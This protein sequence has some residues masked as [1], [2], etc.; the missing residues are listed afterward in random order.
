MLISDT[1]TADRYYQ[2]L[3]A[4]DADFLGTFYVGVRTT[5]IFCIAT[6]RARK[7]KR[8]NVTFYT[9]LKELLDHG[10]RPCKIC[11][12]T[13]HAHRAPAPVSRALALM[14]EKPKEK[15][16][17]RDLREAGVSPDALRRWFNEHYGMTFQAYQRMYRINQAYRELREGAA[18]TRAA[19]ESGY[20]SVSGFGYTYKKLLGKSPHAAARPRVMLLNRITTPLGPMFVGATE[21]GI[22]L[23][24]FV[25]RRMLE[26]ELHDLQKLLGATI[27]T[28]ENEHSRRAREELVDYFAGTRQAFTVPLDLPGTA[29]QQAAWRALHGIPYGTTASYQEQAKAVGNTGA[30]RAVAAANGMNRVSIIVPCHRIIGKDGKLRG[31]GGGVERKRWLLSHERRHRVSDVLT[32]GEGW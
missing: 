10:Y 13:E 3:V 1:A 16:S 24:E 11:R 31:Y 8:E 9:T 12:P 15:I 30:V 28:G 23:L 21:T 32:L 17:D 7:P 22:C 2:A 19:H 29:F 27:L 26:T 18:T 14:R 4:R 6:C 25:D 20:E 5:G